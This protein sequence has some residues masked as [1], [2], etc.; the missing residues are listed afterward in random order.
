MPGPFSPLG[1]GPVLALEEGWDEIVMILLFSSFFNIL[2]LLLLLDLLIKSLWKWV[3]DILVRLWGGRMVCAGEN[4]CAPAR[5][6][7]GRGPDR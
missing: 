7:A 3:W 4:R 1:R 5:S 6:P 2:D